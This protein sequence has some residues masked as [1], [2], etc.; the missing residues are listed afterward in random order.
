MCF[1][2]HILIISH[3]L[4]FNFHCSGFQNLPIYEYQLPWVQCNWIRQPMIHDA[5][6]PPC[7]VSWGGGGFRER[8]NMFSLLWHRF[9]DGPLI[10]KIVMLVCMHVQIFLTQWVFVVIFWNIPRGRA[11]C[12]EDGGEKV[13][14]SDSTGQRRTEKKVLVWYLW[15]D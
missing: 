9:C 14:Y 15:L 1:C 5:H 13:K 3:I 8:L 4:V 2:L 11:A 12:W 6:V 10:K 7:L